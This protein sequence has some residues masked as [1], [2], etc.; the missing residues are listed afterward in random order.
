MTSGGGG[1]GD[2]AADEFAHDAPRLFRFAA[3]EHD[4]VAEAHFALFARRGVGA[5][6]ADF[7]EYDVR[8]QC[9]LG[10]LLVLLQSE[11][12]GD[13]IHIA[14]GALRLLLFGHELEAHLAP[15]CAALPACIIEV[16]A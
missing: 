13:R 15:A 2:A 8:N 16:A 6:S 1:D 3:G 10:V 9:A 5:A 12:R 7:G 4:D 14:L 11:P